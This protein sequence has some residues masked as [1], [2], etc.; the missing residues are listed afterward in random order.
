MNSNFHRHSRR[1][2]SG[3]DSQYLNNIKMSITFRR[4]AFSVWGSQ[5]TKGKTWPWLKSATVIA[6]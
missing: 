4:D 2:V 6:R 1:Q 5:I 3:V